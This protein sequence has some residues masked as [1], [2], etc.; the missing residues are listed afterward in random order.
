MRDPQRESSTAYR[1]A[2]L[3]LLL[4]AMLVTCNRGHREPLSVCYFREGATIYYQYDTETSF[5]GGSR[6]AEKH[7]KGADA[8]T[9][10]PNESPTVKTPLDCR[11]LGDHGLIYAQDNARVYHKYNVIADANPDSFEIVA[12][13]RGYA[14]DAHRVFF[15]DQHIASADPATFVKLDGF[16]SAKDR[17]HIWIRG[18]HPVADVPASLDY[19]SLQLDRSY[20]GDQPERYYR[21]ET[22][23]YYAKSFRQLQAR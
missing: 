10:Q 22:G 19:A 8:Q 15:D 11:A 13:N 17:A 20:H 1:F 16:L 23:R 6:I 9:F 7:V 14:K 4:A 21:D 12:M 3:S 18:K 2:G 5:F